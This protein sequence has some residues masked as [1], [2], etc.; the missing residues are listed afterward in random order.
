LLPLTAPLPAVAASPEAFDPERGCTVLGS[1]AGD[2]L[3]GTNGDDV[4]CGGGGGDTILASAG[5]DI[6]YGDGGGDTIY[7]GAG[8]DTIY[9]GD[10]GD[11]IY[12]EDGAD[13]VQ[14]GAGGDTVYG[15]S[16]AD[17]IWGGDGGDT[18]WG[19]DGPDWIYPEAGADTARGGDGDD[20]IFDQG[21]ADTLWGDAGDDR[22]LAGEGADSVK[23]N[24][25]DDL[26]IGGPGNDSHYGDAGSDRCAGGSGTN[27]YY[28][29]EVKVSLA[30]IGGMD[31]DSDG[32]G[33]PDIAELRGGSDPL[34]R[35]TD[36]DGLDDEAEFDSGT[37]ATAVDSDGDGVL[38]PDEDMDNDGLTNLA[39]VTAGTNG[40]RA[41]T[42]RD[43]INDGE[44]VSAGLNPVEADT[45][46]DGVT[47]GDELKVGSDP[48]AADTDGDGIGDGEDTFTITLDLAE[49]PATLVATGV[50]AGLLET[51]LTPSG[52]LRVSGLPGQRAP[53]VAVH[54]P[55]GVTGFLT[56]AFDAADLPGDADVALLHYDSESDTLERPAR[57]TVDWAAGTVTAQVDEFSPFVVVDA[58]EFAAAWERELEELGGGLAESPLSVMLV[59]DSSASMLANDPGRMRVEAAA[60]FIDALGDQDAVGVIGFAETATT[61][62][63][64]GYDKQEAKDALAQVG[65]SGSANITQA[66][67]SAIR[68]LTPVV[69]TQPGPVAKRVI[70]LL[71]DGTGTYDWALTGQARNKG[72]T[73]YT[74]GL[75]RA[76]NETLLDWI[77]SATGGQFFL[78][79]S[80]GDLAGS[81]TTDLFGMLGRTDSDGDGLTDAA[82]TNG[83]LTSTGKVLFSNPL[84]ADTDGDGLDD[85][86]ELGYEPS[87]GHGFGRGTA[88]RVVSHPSKA[89]T[90]GDG[91]GD[92]AEVSSGWNA[93]DA[94]PDNDGLLDAGEWDAGT[95]DYW[96]DTDSDGFSD[97]EE[98]AR[99]ADGFDPLVMDVEIET[100][101]YISQLLRG[102]LCGDVAGIW[103]FCEGDTWAYLVGQILGGVALPGVGDVRD[104][105]GSSI[106]G[107]FV[108]AGLSLVGVVPLFGDAVKALKTI[109]NFGKV[110]TRLAAQGGDWVRV[111]LRNRVLGDS[112]LQKLGWPARNVSASSAKAASAT[113]SAGVTAAAVFLP[114][115]VP[116][117]S[118]PRPS[119]GALKDAKE[120]LDAASPDVFSRLAKSKNGIDVDD[121]SLVGAVAQM[122][123]HV[124]GVPH[125]ERVLTKAKAVKKAP[126][127]VGGKA[128]DLPNEAACEKWFN[129]ILKDWVKTPPKIA[130]HIPKIP[131]DPT[132]GTANRFYD[133]IGKLPGS[134]VATAFEHKIGWVRYSARVRAQITRDAALLAELKADPSLAGKIGFKKIEWVF[135]AKEPGGV[136]PDKALLEALE[137]VGIPYTIY[138]P[139]S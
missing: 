15:G 36:G 114:A 34:A 138:L 75:G 128:L 132:A 41:D 130:T 119:A 57:Q 1:A 121:P 32:D 19:Q 33:V 125:A 127:S 80:A 50:A 28:S 113:S 93:F 124:D 37:S 97:A 136:G 102:T 131:L 42:D 126:T 74:V 103:G 120:M 29:C 23:G 137:D 5:D 25:G 26:L 21:K 69:P 89:D 98:V 90:D 92:L 86:T 71:T 38:D 91:L 12:A 64:L 61:L 109:K 76:T 8:A 13:V 105:V 72:I 58:G 134:D 10:G 66:M 35:D 107:D 11:T 47:D 3:K 6:I 30:D 115:A 96:G 73:V 62:Q 44:E 59:L 20:L 51:R 31:G 63:S 101:E 53:P 49:P 52:D 54:A 99:A 122:S 22:I 129:S 68:Q 56:V 123:R 104:L 2:I 112:V 106:K 87:Q 139:R 43:G 67:Q 108:S 100:A 85:G 60:A 27:A 78:A 16:G 84:I 133:S 79:D 81:I 17:A 77:A 70:V 88:Y 116:Q 24:A 82:E 118:L 95:F 7:G 18:L 9:G 117:A 110:T 135:F 111:A 55:E 39:E 4:I 65:A 48:A 45:D 83:M 46:G 14:A 40:L 94:D